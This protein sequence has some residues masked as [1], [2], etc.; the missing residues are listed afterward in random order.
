MPRTKSFAPEHAVA[1]AAQLFRVRGYG[2][3]SMGEIAYHFGVSRA[4]LYATFGDKRS[5]FLRALRQSGQLFRTAGPPGLATASAPRDAIID[6]FVSMGDLPTPPYVVLLMSASIDLLPQDWEVAAVVRDE[7][8]AIEDNIR[9]SI[10]RG[11]AQGEIAGW[12]DATHTAPTLLGLF[13][14]LHLLRRSKAVVRAT[15]DQVDALLPPPGRP[16]SRYSRSSRS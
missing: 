5:L 14:G 6:L 13:L 15:A 11:I 16:D 8:T 10:E 7:F 3:T 1:T 9:R 2:A 12:V 4:T